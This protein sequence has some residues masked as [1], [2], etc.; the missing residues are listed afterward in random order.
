MANKE[1]PT[2]EVLRLMKQGTSDSEVIRS[3]SERGYSPVQ[4][5]DALNQAKIKRD[6]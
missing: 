3:L 4:I 2:D 1:T 6:F 5:T